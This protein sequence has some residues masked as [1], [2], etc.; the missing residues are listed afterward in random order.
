MANTIN[1]LNELNNT[2]K[3]MKENGAN[4]PKQP[5]FFQFVCMNK[6]QNIFITAYLQEDYEKT[7]PEFKKALQ[8]Y[9]NVIQNFKLVF[10]ARNDLLSNK[11]ELM[12]EMA[13]RRFL[14]L[15]RKEGIRRIS[16][17]EQAKIM[18]EYQNQIEEFSK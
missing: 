11:E 15:E 16:S 9:Q 6:N 8:K 14:R 5:R 10:S 1:N 17:L 4:Y 3:A 12:I 13:E 7:S 2:V 18:N